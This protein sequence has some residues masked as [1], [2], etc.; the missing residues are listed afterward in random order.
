MDTVADKSVMVMSLVNT[1]G[2]GMVAVAGLVMVMAGS[3]L[4]LTVVEL[5]A[6]LASEAGARKIKLEPRKPREIV[7]RK[8]ERTG[9]IPDN[10]V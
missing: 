7:R 1:S 2:E 3:I 4:R 9:K 10:N 5:V 6:A 8:I